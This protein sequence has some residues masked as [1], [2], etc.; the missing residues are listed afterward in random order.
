MTNVYQRQKSKVQTL[1]MALHVKAKAEP[2]YR[3]YTLW[4][5]VCR[6]DVLRI[7]YQRC[8]ANDGSHGIDRET[9]ADITTMGLELWLGK[10]RKELQDK[11]YCPQP[12]RRVWIPKTNG[13][14][15]RPLSIACIKDRVVQQAMLMII[16]PIFEADFLPAQYGFR[17]KIDAK[18]AIRRVYYHTT[19]YGR[20][21]V[22]DA[23]LKDYFTSIPHGDLMQCMTRRIADKQILQMIKRWLVVPVI[24]ERQTK[25]CDQYRGE[26]QTPWDSP[27]QSYLAATFKLLFPAVSIGMGKVW[28]CRQVQCS[29]C[30]LRR[31]HAG[32][33][34]EQMGCKSPN[35]NCLFGGLAGG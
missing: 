8:Q 21:A 4:D 14:T 16:N 15:L 18:M 2:S 13:N 5:K 22:V 24:E 33:G 35:P 25:G 27:R 20:T 26:R 9:F 32:T 11:S 1:Q 7:A 28:V 6:M 30:K 31:W 10:L 34:V 29:H 23:D 17:P 19:Q 3:F 12:L